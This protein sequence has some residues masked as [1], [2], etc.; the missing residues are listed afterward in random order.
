M[1][2]IHFSA[3]RS[4][5]TA[6]FRWIKS[7]THRDEPLLLDREWSDLPQDCPSSPPEKQTRNTWRR[8]T[9]SCWT[10]WKTDRWT[11]ENKGQVDRQYAYSKTIIYYHRSHF[12][13]RKKL[14][15]A[16]ACDVCALCWCHKTTK[17]LQSHTNTVSHKKTHYASNCFKS[18]CV[19]DAPEPTELL[20][21]D[22]RLQYVIKP[23]R[24]T[25]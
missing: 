19:W 2:V 6:I 21:T 13:H 12:W 17:W 7:C 10:D 1:H 18:C 23:E 20:N 5:W 16:W 25:L 14:S 15:D 9:H 4:I 24:E 22:K 8:M 3:E 11:D